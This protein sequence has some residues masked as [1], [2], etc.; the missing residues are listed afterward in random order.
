MGSLLSLCCG[1][2]RSAVNLWTLDNHL[3]QPAGGAPLAATGFTP[4]YA[5]VTIGGVQGTVLNSPALSP[6]QSLLMPNSGGANGGG[7]K[8]NNWTLVMDV[9]TPATLPQWISLLQTNPAN[10]DDAEVFINSSGRLWAG[11]LMGTGGVI[12]AGTWYRLAIRAQVSP[13]QVLITGFVNGVP[14]STPQTKPLDSTYALGPSALLLSDENGETAAMKIGAVAFWNEA[15]PDAALAVLGGPSA[16]NIDAAS[17]I[18]P[19]R[20]LAWSANGG[21]INWRNA[22]L[23]STSAGGVSAGNYILSGRAWAANMGWIDMGNG[24]PAN[25]IRYQN[26]GV[27]GRPDFGINH[28]GGRLYGLAWGQN[29]GWVNFGPAQA[30]QAWSNSPRLDLVTG[31]VTGV[32]WGQNIGWINLG[33]SGS[34]TLAVKSLQC[35]VDTDNDGIAD[36]W[37]YD[38]DGRLAPNLTRLTA[39]GD[40]DGDGVTDVQ[41]FAADTSP[42]SALDFLRYESVT[43]AGSLTT[44]TWKSRAT[45]VYTNA[46]GTGLSG[47]SLL[48]S[49]TAGTGATMQA[50]QTTADPRRF[51]RL[52]ASCPLQP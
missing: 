49:S 11:S 47:W 31:V 22:T 8:T 1:S 7:T 17:T 13:G 39:T 2:A 15:L 44:L 38:R 25:G 46:T 21:W 26:A 51:Y 50:T 33:Q 24:A 3:A 48:G 6:A 5:G 28:D 35:G 14:Q 34:L 52:S 42:Y 45:R 16:N 27:S 10:S 4:A 12:A 18:D 43:R 41:E 30:A 9:E 19:A 37:E 20:T 23:T 29:I 40:Y 36:A 32:A